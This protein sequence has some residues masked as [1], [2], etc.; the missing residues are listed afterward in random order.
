AAQAGPIAGLPATGGFFFQP[1]V[2]LTNSFAVHEGSYSWAPDL[3]APPFQ[4]PADGAVCQD[5]IVQALPP[6]PLD[7]V[8]SFAFP[9]WLDQALGEYDATVHQFDTGG[10]GDFANAVSTFLD[11]IALLPD[12]SVPDLVIGS[13]QDRCVAYPAVHGRWLAAPWAAGTPNSAETHFV[14]HADP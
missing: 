3:D 8:A 10:L 7:T 13:T 5:L 4:S 14:Y 1:P 9:F 12:T 6:L 2:N 11:V